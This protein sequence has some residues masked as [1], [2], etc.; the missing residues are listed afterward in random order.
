MGGASAVSSLTP[1]L[2]HAVKDVRADAAAALAL[3]GSGDALPHLRA[4]LAV[5]DDPLV[6]LAIID[7]IRVLTRN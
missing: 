6:R 3:T 4:R 7:S 2:E 5:E 1:L